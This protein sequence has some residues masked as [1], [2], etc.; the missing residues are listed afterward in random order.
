MIAMKFFLLIALALAATS[1]GAAADEFTGSDSI[2]PDTLP[3]DETDTDTKSVT[4]PSAWVEVDGVRTEFDLEVCIVSPGFING[5]GLATD[6]SNRSLSLGYH[7]QTEEYGVISVNLLV[8]DPLATDN[9]PSL[10][11]TLDEAPGEISHSLAYVVTDEGISG[12]ADFTLGWA[13]TADVTVASGSFEVTC[14]PQE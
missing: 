11:A 3:L 4:E 8:S 1:C 13:S 5:S 2:T 10:Q 9:T 7:D 14:G 6:G 12:T